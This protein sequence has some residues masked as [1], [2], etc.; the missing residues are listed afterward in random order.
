MNPTSVDVPLACLRGVSFSYKDAPQTIHE[1]T[2]SVNA[3]ECVV[4]CGPSGGG[5]TTLVRLINGL[6]GGF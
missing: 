2:F 3:G 1:A 5:K 4:L 6:A